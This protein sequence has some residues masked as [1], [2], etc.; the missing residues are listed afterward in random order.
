MFRKYVS[1]EEAIKLY[2]DDGDVKNTKYVT[3][4][5]FLEAIESK[6]IYTSKLIIDER[7]KDDI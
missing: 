3:F 6:E 2:P 7:R 1:L 4:E 5:E